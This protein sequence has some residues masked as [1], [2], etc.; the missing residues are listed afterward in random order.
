MITC[1]CV[2]SNGFYLCLSIPIS[3]L[4]ISKLSISIRFSVQIIFGGSECGYLIGRADE[5]Q[6]YGNC[7]C[8]VRDIM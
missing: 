7:G 3:P 1:A 5:R 2:P 4:C 8:K 6:E